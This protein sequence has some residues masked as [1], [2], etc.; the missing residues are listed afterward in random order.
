MKGN[1]QDI[2]LGTF[3]CLAT[4]NQNKRNSSNSAQKRLDQLEKEHD[5]LQIRKFEMESP[6]S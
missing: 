2:Y 1:I 5:K 6:R 4:E 3:L